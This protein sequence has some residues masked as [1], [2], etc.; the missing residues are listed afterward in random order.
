MDCHPFVST[1]RDDVPL[2]VSQLH[3]IMTLVN[4]ERTQAMLASI[5]VGFH[6]DPSRCVADAEIQNLPL[7]DQ[8][9]ERLHK[10]G[11][12]GS[13]VVDMDE[14]LTAI[15]VHS[16]YRIAHEKKEKKGKQKGGVYQVNIISLQTLET[17]ANGNVHAFRPRTTKVAPLARFTHPRA[18]RV[19]GS[20]DHFL[21]PAGLS[22]PLSNPS[23]ALPV[24]IIVC[25]VD[26]VSTEVVKR[27]QQLKGAFLGAFAQETSPLVAETYS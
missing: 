22:Q 9:I 19:L 10:L 4:G 11:D 24:V 12:S 15:S 2:K 14:I 26:E 23:F 3:G 6:N 27:V 1:H 7:L 20:D 8:V 16:S 21:S 18:R 25:R 5:S 17:L 13:K